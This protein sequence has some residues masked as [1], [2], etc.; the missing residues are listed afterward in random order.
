MNF[1]KLL[2]WGAVACGIIAG[3]AGVTA[4]IV[5]KKAAFAAWGVMFVSGSVIVAISGGKGRP[6]GSLRPPSIGAR[7]TQVP[8]WA[9]AVISLLFVPAVVFTFIFPPWK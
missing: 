3:I 2:F 4:G 7:F 1:E 8:A 6:D 9:W 5:F